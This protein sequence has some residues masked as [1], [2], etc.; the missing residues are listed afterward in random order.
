VRI[1]HRRQIA[2]HSP[3][4]LGRRLRLATSSQQRRITLCGVSAEIERKFLVSA[5]PE[6]LADCPATRIDQGYLA[7]GER[8]EVRLRRAGDE[9][10]LTAKRGH[11]EV[12]E[13]AEISLDGERFDELWPLTADQRLTKTRHLVPLEDGLRAE[14]DVYARPLQGL[15]TAEVEFESEA[16]ARSFQP[17]D[18]LG[19]ELTGD[20]RYSNQSLASR[21][22]PPHDG[23]AG[24][25]IEG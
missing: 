16:R 18:W 6:W 14:V 20:A 12:R 8:S 23:A 10:T 11:G 13:E 9:L 19:E 1:E 24:G 4:S 17:P 22:R 3:L 2:H 7:V 5:V 15:V 25:R 21:G